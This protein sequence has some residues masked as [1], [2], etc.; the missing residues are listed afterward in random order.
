MRGAI[1]L[2]GAIMVAATP[3]VA[4][5]RNGY[6]AIAAGDLA[7]AE[8]TL[9]AERRIFPSR[10]ELMLNLAAVYA[11]TGRAAQAAT[12]YQEALAA[13]SILLDLPDGTTVA[14]HAVAQRGLARLAP[15]HFATR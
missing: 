14:S 12:L 1:I 6:Q 10:P 13:D 9:V 15:T 2:L 4:G 8:R 3:A 5:D 11:R 7:R